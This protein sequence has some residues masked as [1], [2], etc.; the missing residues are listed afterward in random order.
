MKATINSEG[1]LTISAESELESYAMKKW[2]DTNFD[3]DKGFLSHNILIDCA[4]N[5]KNS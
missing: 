4:V 2:L 3:D 5:D 1:V